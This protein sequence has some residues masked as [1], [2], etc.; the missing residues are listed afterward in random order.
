MELE[1]FVAETQSFRVEV[2]QTLA[3]SNSG[4]FCLPPARLRNNRRAI[5]YLRAFGP[6]RVRF[7]PAMGR[8]F[9]LSGYP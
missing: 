2:P 8:C 7:G 9:C 3:G 6:P 1:A 4:E 5:A